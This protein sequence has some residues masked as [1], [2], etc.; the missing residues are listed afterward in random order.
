[1]GFLESCFSYIFGD[2]DPNVNFEEK[3]YVVQGLSVYVAGVRGGGCT[4]CSAEKSC[5]GDR[6]RMQLLCSLLIGSRCG[7]CICAC[8]GSR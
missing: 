8:S 6:T 2:G 5:T 4:D 1:M 7:L 3:R